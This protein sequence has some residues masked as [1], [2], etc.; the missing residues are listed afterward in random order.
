MLFA[1]GV[2]RDKRLWNDKIKA[3]FKNLP[4]ILTPLRAI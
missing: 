2:L 3:D 4:A 1:N